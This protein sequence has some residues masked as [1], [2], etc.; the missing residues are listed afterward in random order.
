MQSNWFLLQIQ[1]LCFTF[2]GSASFLKR[3]SLVFILFLII[4]QWIF[5]ILV[6][7][8]MLSDFFF[9]FRIKIPCLLNPNQFK[10]FFMWN[11]PPLSSVWKK[12][13]F[14]S[15][16]MRSWSRSQ[17]PEI[18]ENCHCQ[19][20]S[21]SFRKCVEG[22]GL[23]EKTAYQCGTKAK[24]VLKKQYYAL[25]SYKSISKA[26]EPNPSIFG[27]KWR[28]VWIDVFVPNI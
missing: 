14:C 2:N 12:I 1:K 6:T 16:P 28:K 20:F 18:I 8:C 5:L 24:R 22:V 27:V 19:L 3:Y 26:F 13:T 9:Y 10:I 17:E 7:F 4:F 21:H 23:I 15:M 25:M 11:K